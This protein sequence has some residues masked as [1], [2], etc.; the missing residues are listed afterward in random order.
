M[1]SYKD[2]A[3]KRAHVADLYLQGKNSK[4]IAYEIG[5]SRRYVQKIVLRLIQEGVLPHE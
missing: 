5:L 1:N 4:Q 2:A 3:E